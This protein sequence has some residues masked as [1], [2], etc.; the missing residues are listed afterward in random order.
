MAD[1]EKNDPALDENE[2]ASLL[3]NNP[4][5]LKHSQNIL[6]G[7]VILL[8]SLVLI[9]RV[10]SSSKANAEKD[11]LT[12]ETEYSYLKESK[13]D[14]QKLQDVVNRHAELHPKYDGIFVR[15][16]LRQG[17]LTEAK[18][19][20]NIAL[21]RVSDNLP[22]FFE[23][24]SKTSLLIYEKKHKEALEQAKEL[25]SEI[26]N[27]DSSLYIY[28]LLR[29]AILEQELGSKSGEQEAWKIL[30]EQLKKTSLETVQQNFQDQGTTLFNYI[31]A[32]EE[33]LAQNGH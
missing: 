1:K 28:N 27:N 22:E 21:T 9:Y 25:A 24:Y 31:Q 10:T 20:A 4:F 17:K 12:A 29:I 5:F 6:Y 16:F 3:S 7:I 2:W 13:G 18:E 14:L 19:F 30:K 15:S 23:K 33:Q 11:Y 8:I 32:R 26:N